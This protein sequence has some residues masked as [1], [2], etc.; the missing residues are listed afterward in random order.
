MKD[1]HVGTAFGCEC[2]RP[3][4]PSV[5]SR[6]QIPLH[7]LQQPGRRSPAR[8]QMAGRDCYSSFC[9]ISSKALFERAPV[10]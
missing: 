7:R 6:V 4:G 8:D 2:G 9:T 5:I 3:D 1:E 10:I